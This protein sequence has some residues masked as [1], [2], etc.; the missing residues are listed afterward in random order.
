VGSGPAL[1]VVFR[2]MER[3]FRPDHADG[4][5]GEIQYE[6]TG[7]NGARVW[8]IRVE[9]DHAVALAGRAFDPAVT[10]RMSVPTFARVL[11]GEL[12]P[13]RAFL[14]GQLVVEGDLALASRLGRMFPPPAPD[15]PTE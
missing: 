6:L 9:G 2:G 10:L 5:T 7:T 4:F 15:E 14:G 12:E 8:T 13:G 11:T 3:A 1:R